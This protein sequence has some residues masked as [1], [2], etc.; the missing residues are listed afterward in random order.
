MKLSVTL[1]EDV[2]E[3]LRKLADED[4]RQLSS[5]MNRVLREVLWK[6]DRS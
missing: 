5:Y 1:D 6:I 3:R 4:D 2:V